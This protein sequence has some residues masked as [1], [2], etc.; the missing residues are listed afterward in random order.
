M[1]GSAAIRTPLF[2]NLA[3]VRAELTPDRIGLVEMR[4]VKPS[5][6]DR[7]RM[8]RR[9][10]G[11]R[12]KALERKWEVEVGVGESLTFDPFD[13]NIHIELLRQ[14]LDDLIVELRRL[15]LLEHRERIL[16]ATDFGGNLALRQPGLAAGVLELIADL[17]T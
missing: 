1:H 6:V 5:P 3:A 4:Q 11:V 8:I 10:P 14:L 13:R 17:W 9:A 7:V 2:Q 16:L 15:P 12:T